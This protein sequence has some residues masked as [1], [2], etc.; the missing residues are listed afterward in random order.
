MRV[1]LYCQDMAQPN[2]MSKAA[3]LTAR[4]FHGEG[5]QVEILAETVASPR[6]R[7]ALFGPAARG[8]TIRTVGPPRGA[9]GRGLVAST[10]GYDLFINQLP[11]PCFP[12]FARRSWLWVRCVPHA[13]PRYLEFYRL[14][15]N[16]RYTR[17][18]L[19][20]RWGLAA[21]ILHPPV[22]VA[23]FAPLRKER[24][25]LSV[26]TLGGGAR[27]KNELALVRLFKRLHAEGRLK[28]W[29]YHLAGMLEGGP[30]WL[31][32]LKAEAAGAPIRFQVE[33][34]L[35]ELKDLY[36]RASLLW[37]ACGAPV[38]RASS[39]ENREHFG[40][41][42]VEAMAAGCVPLAPDAGGPREIIERGRTGALYRSWAGLR[43]LTLAAIEGRL[44]L[45]R[46]AREGRARSRFYGLA[47][48]KRR[49]RALLAGSSHVA[50]GCGGSG[51]PR[52]SASR[53]GAGRGW[54]SSGGPCARGPSRGV[55]FGTSRGLVSCA[56]NR[57]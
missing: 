25:I 56:R 57:G 6:R 42:L 9:A 19:R 5:H 35:D 49:L 34:G 10:A 4:V 44:P 8:L 26:G 55:G 33:A 22:W 28:G 31:A 11:G 1:A 27:P 23:D 13:R 38:V 43:A 53:Q 50:R 37:H 18:R 16:S 14:L 41:A 30:A 17:A 46:L 21:E 7:Q 3:I 54:R 48:F 40:V 32:R 2:G 15:A 29:R 36:G 39:R 51:S 52:R 47:A 45:A 12:S 24:L 20:R